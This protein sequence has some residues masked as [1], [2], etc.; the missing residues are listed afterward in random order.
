MGASGLGGERD[1]SP[2]AGSRHLPLILFTLVL[3]VAAIIYLLPLY[4]M[5]TGSLKAQ[6]GIMQTPPE[7]FPALPTLENWRNLFSIKT[8]SPWTWFKNS[9]IVAL[10]TVAVSVTLSAL[11]G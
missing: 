3:I 10:G 5:F 2:G 4:W 1:A 6:K 8:I 11:A 9:V 7:W